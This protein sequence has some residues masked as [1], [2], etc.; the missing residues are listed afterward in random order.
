MSLG[1]NVGS[2]HRAV[3]LIVGVALIP[4]PHL[5]KSPAL[6]SDYALYGLSAVGG[7]PI[8]T[9]LVSFCPLYRIIG[10]RTCSKAS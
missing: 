10:V 4:I 6:T 8:L 7:I 2:F 1:A 5:A 9:G 3:C